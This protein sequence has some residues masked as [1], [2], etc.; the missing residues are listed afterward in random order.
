MR[1]AEDSVVDFDGGWGGCGICHGGGG[2]SVSGKREAK[3]GDGTKERD[4]LV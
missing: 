4:P 2:G 3:G 1:L